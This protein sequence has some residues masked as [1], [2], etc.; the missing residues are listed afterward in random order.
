M[1]IGTQRY[2][3]VLCLLADG[4]LPAC[5]T[6][7]GGMCAALEI[8]LEGGRTILVTDAEDSLAWDPFEHR[9]WGVGLYSPGSEYDDGPVRFVD[10]QDGSSSALLP[11]IKQLLI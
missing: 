8:R 4:G 9:G 1:E 7:T 11:L 10:S 5:F 3:D 6:Q 2:A